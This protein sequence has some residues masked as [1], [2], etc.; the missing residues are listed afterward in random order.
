[1]AARRSCG[2]IYRW[3]TP[4]ILAL[5]VCAASLLIA[6]GLTGDGSEPTAEPKSLP[7]D[8]DRYFNEDAQKPR[9]NQE[10]NGILVGPG[11]PGEFGAG[12]EP[13]T[14]V[15]DRAG[16]E[17]QQ[18]P[19][20]RATGTALDV[21]PAYLP[22]GV[23]PSPSATAVE[24]ME[25]GG[26]V[27]S[28]AKYYHVPPKYSDQHEGVLLWSGGEFSIWRMLS[29]RHAF[30]LS[31][32]AERMGPMTIAGRAGVLMRPVMPAD[33]DVGVGDM[34]IVIAEDFGLTVIQGSGLPVDEFIKIAEGLY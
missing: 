34:A 27:I 16:A 15:C 28:V 21:N 12:V 23:Q 3:A 5:V 24:L 6:C 19:R 8:W 2:A 25:C 18:A 9:F 33:V 17:P 31:G 14:D 29:T 22:E 13:T 30:P 7:A 20:E 1:M 32:A 26:T 11:G 4:M 10:I